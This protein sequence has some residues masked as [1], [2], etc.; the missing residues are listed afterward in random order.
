M[1]KF[2]NNKYFFENNIFYNNR[3]I[4]WG[5]AGLS[6][7]IMCNV[8]G[9]SSDANLYKG[10]SEGGEWDKEKFNVTQKADKKFFYDIKN[11]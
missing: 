3:C 1:R 6:W 5:G 10:I 4:K 7:D 8:R 2:H 9:V 11:T